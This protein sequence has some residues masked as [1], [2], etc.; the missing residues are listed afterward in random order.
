GRTTLLQQVGDRIGRLS[1]QHIDVERTATTPER[2]FRAIAT[3]SPYPVGDGTSSGARQAFDQTLTFL[4]L[5]R[6]PTGEPATFL[7]DEF[8]ELRTFESFPG[9]RRVL[10]EL[11]E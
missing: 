8:L 4:D 9:L 2:F 10:H 5:A 6:M 1:V 11:I 7:L 3:T